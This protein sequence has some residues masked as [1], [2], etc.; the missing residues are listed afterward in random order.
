MGVLSFVR[1]LDRERRLALELTADR[2]AGYQDGLGAAWDDD[3]VRTCRP[4]AA[5]PARRA[6]LDWLRSDARPTAIL[7][8]SDV[9]ALGALQAATE[10]GITVPDELS[11]VGFDDG[12]VA[13]IATP[14][15]TTVAQPFEEKGRLAAEWLIEAVERDGAPADAGRRTILPTKL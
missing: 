14:A 1:A 5:E 6:T 12:P 11:V 10:L 7:A 9:L 3:L 15:L 4:D 2:L 13:A 8:M